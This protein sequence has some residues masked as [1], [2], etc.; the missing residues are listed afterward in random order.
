MANGI[1]VWLAMAR[2]LLHQK[3]Q[4]GKVLNFSRHTDTWASPQ[5]GR[6]R[7]DGHTLYVKW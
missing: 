1:V 5:V 3:Q 4:L 2:A 6:P 7:S